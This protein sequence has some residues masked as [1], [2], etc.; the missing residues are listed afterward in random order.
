MYVFIDSVSYLYVFCI[1]FEI[2]FDPCI[3]I[4]SQQCG[5]IKCSYWLKLCISATKLYYFKV[6][7]AFELNK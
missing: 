7:M 3:L 4:D 2:A 1:Q 5:S 6:D